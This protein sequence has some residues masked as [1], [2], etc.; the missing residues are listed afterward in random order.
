MSSSR[1]SVESEWLTCTGGYLRSGDEVALLLEGMSVSR[2]RR[3]P[4]NESE[5]VKVL[6]SGGKGAE[7]CARG[8]VA[9]H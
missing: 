7:R 2:H 8:D 5:T 1:S 3:C 9:L 4:S 6:Y